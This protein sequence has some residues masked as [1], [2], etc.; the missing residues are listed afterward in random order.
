MSSLQ[1]GS[2]GVAEAAHNGIQSSEAQDVARLI[3]Q[4]TRK[5]E[6]PPEIAEAPE[7]FLKKLYD[8]WKKNGGDIAGKPRNSQRRINELLDEEGETIQSLQP[9][10]AGKTRLRRPDALKLIRLFLICWEYKGDPEKDDV[11]KEDYSSI[12]DLNI[13]D[14]TI[15]LVDLI[16]KKGTHEYEN[17][18]RLPREDD[19]LGAGNAP[20]ET[21]RIIYELFEHSDILITI[22]S[23]NSII[24]PDPIRGIYSIRNTID[25]LWKISKN[26]NNNCLIAWIVDLGSREFS[27]ESSVPS[28]YNIDYLATQFRVLGAFEDNFANERW[29]WLKTHTAFVVGSLRLDEIDSWYQDEEKDL[30]VYHTKWPSIQSHHALISALPTD[31]ARSSNMHILYGKMLDEIGTHSFTL[32]Y[33]KDGWKVPDTSSSEKITKFRY[34][35]NAPSFENINNDSTL[36]SDIATAKSLELASPGRRYDEALLLVCA[37]IDK[38]IGINQ[39]GHSDNI[40]PREAMAHLRL[41]GL[42]VLRLNEFLTLNSHLSTR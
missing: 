6:L 40:D 23:Y 21:K 11:K 34:F 7:G 4:V 14:A 13:D 26:C 27:D 16:F 31:W 9:K 41:R 8:V 1:F 35:A 10:L 28:F 30:H 20:R 24:A 39:A 19:E 38:R 3:R 5:E 29:E 15:R 32:F 33:K 25:T 22:S 36:L 42:A 18:V 17:G 12:N 2:D 37:V